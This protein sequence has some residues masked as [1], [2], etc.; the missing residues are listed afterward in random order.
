M[1]ALPAEDHLARIRHD[2]DRLG[3][4]ARRDV[5][6]AEDQLQE[7]RGRLV[8]LEMAA[9]GLVTSLRRAQR[10]RYEPLPAHLIP[11]FDH[12]GRP[13]PKP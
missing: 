3:I 13:I 10:R 1:R 12:K 9:R 6:V 11:D 8:D 4:D 5:A 7:K 2:V